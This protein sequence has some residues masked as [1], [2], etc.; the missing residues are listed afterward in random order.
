MPPP[1]PKS[2]HTY[3]VEHISMLRSYREAPERAL[4]DPT[5]SGKTLMLKTYIALDLRR[6]ADVVRPHE[7]THAIIAAPQNHTVS[8]FCSPSDDDAAYEEVQLGD[9]IVDLKTNGLRQPLFKEAIPSSA[10]DAN[11]KLEM[12]E[13]YLRHSC[14]AHALV[15]THTGLAMI[16]SQIEEWIKTGGEASE[17]PLKTLSRMVLVVDEAH[18]A[19]AEQ[20]RKFIRLVRRYGTKVIRATATPSRTKGPQP[21]PEG[22]KRIYRSYSTHANEGYAPKV[23]NSKLIPVYGEDITEDDRKGD[24]IST[25]ALA[26]QISEAQVEHWKNSDKPKL[27]ILVP[28]LSNAKD[29]RDGV[30]YRFLEKLLERFKAAGARVF[31]AADAYDDD[32]NAKNARVAKDFHDILK[33]EKA[34]ATNKDGGYEASEWDVIIGSHRLRE[35]TDWPLCSAVYFVGMPG[36]LWVTL[37]GAGRA[38]RDKRWIKGY[39]QD[40]VDKVEICFFVPCASSEIVALVNDE[41]ARSSLV[42][43]C[44]LADFTS[45]QQLLMLSTIT[46]GIARSFRGSKKR[47]VPEVPPEAPQ[48]SQSAPEASL[49]GGDVEAP[50]EDVEGPVARSIDELVV[51]NEAEQLLGT[52]VSAKI[53]AAMALVEARRGSELPADVLIDEILL[54]YKTL[55]RNDENET[56]QRDVVELYVQGIKLLEKHAKKDPTV[57]DKFG[58]VVAEEVR[59]KK[60]VREAWRAAFERVFPEWRRETVSLDDQ[61]VRQQVEILTRDAPGYLNRIAT[62]TKKRLG[63]AW[64]LARMQSFYEQKERVPTE[65]DGAL[66]DDPTETWEEVLDAARKGAR[67]FD[68]GDLEGLIDEVRKDHWYA[69]H[70]ELLLLDSRAAILRVRPDFNFRDRDIAEGVIE[71]FGQEI[72]E[73]LTREQ[74]LNLGEAA[75]E[76]RMK[77]NHAGLQGFKSELL[78]RLKCIAPLRVRLEALERQGD[79]DDTAAEI[80]ELRSKIEGAWPGIQRRVLA[81]HVRQLFNSMVRDLA[82]DRRRGADA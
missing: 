3:Q 32:G 9:V 2:C 13:R 38:T 77:K 22:A 80:L 15:C 78:R 4:L 74:M 18:H 81:K 76:R 11:G 19:E 42:T 5:G 60:S 66:L 73:H 20:L 31:N 7:F 46:A 69:E 43:S 62:L 34:A 79:D 29:D 12:I 30:T 1:K 16:T 52:E 55:Q 40:W 75:V 26:E 27:M 6:T 51:L 44:A 45:T 56:V 17:V 28:A 36:A 8:D 72:A 24:K 10:K 70:S 41:H 23:I 63:R 71:I 61:V 50:P 57:T 48:D 33:K 82:A 67:G 25:I 47:P 49:E 59:K 65:R 35:A 14:P 54:Q 53:R 64:L 21:I 37:Q 58:D 39:P 68:E